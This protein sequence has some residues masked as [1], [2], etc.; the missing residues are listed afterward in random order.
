[1]HID[2]TIVWSYD[3]G[4]NITSRTE[5][6][7]TTGSVGTATAWTGTVLGIEAEIAVATGMIVA[8][9]SF[10]ISNAFWNSNFQLFEWGGSF[11]PDTPKN[12]TPLPNFDK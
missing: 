1:M 6:A 12:N 7:Y 10:V 8:N 3:V 11:T 2:K 5:Y 9:V 4:G